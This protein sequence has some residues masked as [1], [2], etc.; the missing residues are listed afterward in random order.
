MAAINKALVTLLPKKADAMDIKEYRPVSLISGPIKIFDKV[1][2]IRLA[3]DLPKLI[4]Q[5]QSAFIKGRSLHDNFMLVQCTARRLHVLKSPTVLLKLDITKA[6]DSISWPFV[7]EVLRRFGFG[8][9]WIAWI[10]GLLA[11]SFTR[12]MVNGIPGKPILACQGL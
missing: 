6:F 8:E 11:T 1:L 12:I 9:K 4:G 3:E 5:H 2:A 7:I 10:C